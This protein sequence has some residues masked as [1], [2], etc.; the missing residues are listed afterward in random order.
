MKVLLTA[1][2]QSHIVQFHKP[3]VEML[4]AHGCEVHV[5]A[6]DNLAEKNGLRLDFVERVFD[7]PF[8]RSPKSPD[9]LQ[10]YKQ[11]KQI[12]DEGRYDVVHCN[13][14][15]GGIVTRLAARD[16]RKQGTK[17]F[18]TAHGFHFY[19]GAPKKNWLVFYPIEK[20]FANHYT[21][22]LI[23]ITT[24]D[25]KL[26]SEKFH[27][28]VARIHGVGVDEKRYYPV[29]ESEKQRLR[30]E[31]GFTPEQKIILN[32][33]ELLPNKNQQMA[34]RMM[35]GIV[36]EYPDALLLIAG[37]GPEKENLERLIDDLK[38]KS[39]VRLLG[40][41]TNLQEYQHITDV[42]V[43]CSKREG[44]P[45]NIV[46]AMMSGTPVVA[47][48]NRGHRELIQDGKN[49]YLVKVDDVEGMGKS[50]RTLFDADMRENVVANALE[51]AADYHNVSVKKELCRIYYPE[52]EGK[53]NG[54]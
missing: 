4:H 10:A 30:A 35:V 12:I 40:Y 47:S 54:L 53:M 51:Y 1:T 32:I 37:N 16:A 7:V 49:G 17:V 33:G 2:V 20:F 31:M 25:Y 29:D 44:L 14:P 52:S 24:E 11:L 46:E 43:A 48:M 13:T 26:A 42:C 19:Q 36:K 41:V 8:A 50:V 21:D 28:E 5:A 15:M 45:L 9:N 6:K 34:I 22:K 3:L 27:C 38:L 18:Y 23:T 39:N